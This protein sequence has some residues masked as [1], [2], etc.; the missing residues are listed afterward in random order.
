M[1]RPLRNRVS[2]AVYSAQN[3]FAV[4]AIIRVAHSFL[5]REIILIGQSPWYEKA[6]MGMQRFEEVVVLADERAFFEH[7]EGRPLWA[8]EKDH[9]TQSLYDVTSYPDD[10]VLVLGS[11][12]AGLPSVILQRADAVLGI[13]M[14]GVNHSFPLAVAAGIVMSDWARRRYAPGTTISGPARDDRAAAAPDRGGK[15]RPRG[16]RG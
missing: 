11:E 13:P 6:S 10:V 14:Y 7:A 12:R 9:A 2:V 8:V 1:L 16:Q 5:V 3:A 15:D 4:G